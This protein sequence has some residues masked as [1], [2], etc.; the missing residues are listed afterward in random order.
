MFTP[1]CTNKGAELQRFFKDNE[2]AFHVDQYL[3]TIAHVGEEHRHVFADCHGGYDLP[4]RQMLAKSLSKAPSHLDDLTS[5]RFKSVRA[6][7]HS[8]SALN[9]EN[10]VRP[11]PLHTSKKNRRMQDSKETK[12]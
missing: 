9:I 4:E 1:L 7:Q 5:L 2:N 11:F 8:F 12:R 3:H 10:L 6:S